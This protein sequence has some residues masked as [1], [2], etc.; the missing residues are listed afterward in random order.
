MVQ[1]SWTLVDQFEMQQLTKLQANI[2]KSDDLKWCGELREYDAAVDRVTSRS[3]MRVQRFDDRDFYYVTT[4]D[5]PVIEELAQQGEAT[6]FATDAILA[7]LMSCTRSVFPWDIVAQRVNNMVFFDKR[8]ES[9]FDLLTVN[10]NASEP[11]NQDDPE[12]MNHPDRL[13]LEATMINQN[14]SQQVLKSGKGAFY[15]K[16]DDA[17]P[18]AG[19]DSKP[20]SGAYRYRKF[21]LGGGLNLVARCEVQG[22][23]LK[24]GDEQI[25]NPTL[26]VRKPE[27]DERILS[28]TGYCVWLASRC[29]SGERAQE[30][31]AQ[32]GQVDGAGS[33][34]RRGRDE[35]GLR[36]AL[37]LQG[38]VLAR[39]AGHAVVQPE[40]V[41]HADRAQPEQHVGHH[42]DAVRAAA[43]AARG[44]VCDHEGP[45]QAHHAP[46]LGAARHLR[47]G[48]R[49]RGRGGRRCV[50]SPYQFNNALAHVAAYFTGTQGDS[51]T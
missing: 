45:E 6:V 18:F 23:S 51:R 11:P 7:H 35:G 41:R 4:T 50:G 49:G 17:N 9:N 21:D 13:S 1:A 5:D 22:V 33:A 8:D 29:H 42:Q 30:Q 31:L 38:P 28:L 3:N 32:A 37:E 20:A 26:L 19:D 27:K 10:E 43:G 48:G 36:V 16:F 25:A 24:K 14:L 12:H 44:Q 46:V 40:H 15:K 39:G 47:G 2:P 34:G